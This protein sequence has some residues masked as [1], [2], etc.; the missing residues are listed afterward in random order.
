MAPAHSH[1]CM[2]VHIRETNGECLLGIA[3]AGIAT[4]TEGLKSRSHASI[5]MSVH[6]SI[7]SLYTCYTHVDTYVYT[8]AL[9]KFEEPEHA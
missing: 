8:C 4:R 6:M 7:H 9:V 5:H 3:I 1:P 2:C